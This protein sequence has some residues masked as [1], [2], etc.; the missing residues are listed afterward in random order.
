MAPDVCS[1]TDAPEKFLAAQI[2]YHT[3]LEDRGGTLESVGGE[4]ARRKWKDQIDNL[5]KRQ[6]QRRKE[7]HAKRMMEEEFESAEE[8]KIFQQLKKNVFMYENIQTKT[9]VHDQMKGLQDRSGRK[10]RQN[11]KSSWVEPINMNFDDGEWC[12]EVQ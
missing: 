4:E 9:R 11:R 2:A 1:A 5:E 7:T 3:L 12:H 10:R 6:K 8:R